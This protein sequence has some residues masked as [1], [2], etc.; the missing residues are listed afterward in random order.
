MDAIYPDV[1]AFVADTR[2]SA[3]KEMAMRAARVDGVA[4]LTWGLPSF[5]TP[6]SIRSAVEQALR[7]DPDIGKYTLPDGLPE[8]RAQVARTH[9]EAT[10]VEVDA[11]RHVSI[12]AGNMEAVQ[13]L[14]RTVLDAGDEVIVTDPGFASHVLQI[15]LAGGVPVY[16]SLDE[17]RGWALDL[18]TL[19]ELVTE[20]TKAI[21]LVTPSNPTGR[22]FSEAELRV[23]GEFARERG[24]LVILDDPYSHFTY[25]HEGGAFNLSSVPELRDQIAYLFTFSKCHA[26]SGF[27]VGYAV[28][29]AWL[30]GELLKVHDATLICAPR[31]SQV[32]ALAALTGEQEHLGE[33]EATLGRRRTLIGDRLRRVPHVFD[34][35]EPEGA[36][37]V[38]PR[39]VAEHEDSRE[40]AIRLL[41]EAHV[42]V[43]PGAAFGPTGEGH[44]RMAFCVDDEAIE[45]AFDRIE[46]YFG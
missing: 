16:W 18:E 11:D 46:D 10:G 36:Y 12:T 15:G 45:C 19:P 33:F 43:T 8:L 31:I 28:L 42:A 23:V 34:F 7:D 13:T 25:G 20:R 39:I 1:S 41:E 38:F 14:L 22:I 35:V 30:K 27:R 17:H 29:P 37:Y 44:V 9:L 4:S 26:L 32:A 2:V 6:S 5:R 40:F 3:I 21:L 24:L